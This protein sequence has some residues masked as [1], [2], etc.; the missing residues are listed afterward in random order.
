[1]AYLP[2]RYILVRT[3]F[4]PL[5][6]SVT[7]DD[8]AAA[9]AASAGAVHVLP[10]DGVRFS[11]FAP[12]STMSSRLRF[13]PMPEASTGV[14]TALGLQR[15]TGCSQMRTDVMRHR[16]GIGRT[17]ET[18]REQRPADRPADAADPAG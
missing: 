3:R 17:P 12:P 7:D 10:L 18:G 9:A 5:G 15:E 11:W 4:S 13:A 2:Q 8:A 16:K 6:L 14:A 1:M